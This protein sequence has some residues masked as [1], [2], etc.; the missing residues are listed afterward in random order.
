MRAVIFDLFGTLV[1]NL[2]P[3]RLRLAIL[4][5]S[6]SIAAPPAGFERVWNETFAHRMDGRIPDGVDQFR[7]FAD[8]L[9][10]QVTRAQLEASSEVRRRFMLESLQA[11]PAA[12]ECLEA[13]KEMG[14]KLGMSTDCSSE[15]PHLLQRTELG[16]HFESIAASALLRV[17]KP[18]PSMYTSVLD[19]LGVS[20]EECI[21][22]GDGNSE[23]LP[24]AKRHGMTTIWVDN[25]AEQHFQ[26]RFAPGGDHS[27]TCL[28][29]IPPLIVW[30]LVVGSVLLAI[31]GWQPITQTDWAS[32]PFGVYLGIVHLAIF[33]TAITFYLIQYA[34]VTLP[35][36]K[37]MA[38]TYLIPAFVLAQNII[39]GAPWPGMSVIAGVGVIA[40][41]M[42]LLQ[43][44][45]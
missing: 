21:Y 15:T 3:G 18:H 10:L 38:Y 44:A 26:E 40:A 32:V 8:R 30:T 5:M 29:E 39:L 31:Y 24:G 7:P 19:D 1:P 11:K 27:V 25:G 16:S 23:E 42:V 34:S 4:A 41:A 36:A 17:R 22:V 14:L 45:A 12:V 6:N 37:V 13:L 33:T 20:G 28:S 9:G 43:R 2:D 35:S